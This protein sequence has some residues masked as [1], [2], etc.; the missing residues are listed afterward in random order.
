MADLFPTAQHLMPPL[1]VNT[2]QVWRHTFV[3]T[4]PSSVKAE[5]MPYLSESES[6]E[7]EDDQETDLKQDP[8]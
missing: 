2:E 1:I 8:D 5:S 6:E 4:K 3:K 7:P